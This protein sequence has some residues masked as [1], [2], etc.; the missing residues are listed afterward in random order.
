MQFY[1]VA[2]GHINLVDIEIF[3]KISKVLRYLP[4][5][6]FD[7]KEQDW[8]LCKNQV[9]CHLICRALARH[10]EVSVHD[11]YFTPGCQHSWLTTKGGS[12]IDVYPI[13]G[14]VP[15]IVASNGFSP[16]TRLYEE[17]TRFEK[18]LQTPEFISRLEQTIHAVA[19]VIRQLN[20]ESSLL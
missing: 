10:F 15:F 6:I 12:I 19:E 18:T 16:W 14:A 9:T 8:G 4:D 13:A 17:S 2:E 20:S 7:P 3:D 5:L 11:G 1:A